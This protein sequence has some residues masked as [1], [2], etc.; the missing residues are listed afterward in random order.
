MILPLLAFDECPAHAKR[1]EVFKCNRHLVAKRQGG[2]ERRRHNIVKGEDRVAQRAGCGGPPRR[3]E[4]RVLLRVF[5]DERRAVVGAS[6]KK[7]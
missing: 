4:Q 1:G 7:A 2:G 3:G 5:D 6:F